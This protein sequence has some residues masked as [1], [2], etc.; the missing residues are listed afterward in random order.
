MREY[1]PLRVKASRKTLG[2]LHELRTA[3]QLETLWEVLER[4]AETASEAKKTT[5]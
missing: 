4:L 5:Q 2:R 3:W 1:V